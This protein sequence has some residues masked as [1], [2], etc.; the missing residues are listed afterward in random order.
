ML[1][2]DGARQNSRQVSDYLLCRDCEHRFNV[3]GEHYVMSLVKSKNGFPL[4]ETL[5]A[6]KATHPRLAEDMAG[7]S[8]A[9]SPTID[10]N[11]LA[12]FAASVFWRASVHTWTNDDGTSFRTRLG[13]YEEAFR[14][15]LLGGEFPKQAVLTVFACSDKYS[16]ET[17]FMPTFRRVEEHYGHG[18][19]SRGIHFVMNVGKIISKEIRRFGMVGH[20]E[21]L[22]LVTDCFAHEMWRIER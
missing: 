8:A 22:I 7:Y 18:F 1:S 16:Q 20:D 12:Y 6:S 13:K 9:D 19:V 21:Q 5:K 2:A 17:F 4:L 14:Q 10:R 15:Y 11:K 3:S